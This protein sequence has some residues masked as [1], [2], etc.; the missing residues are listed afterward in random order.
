[1]MCYL[2]YYRVAVF[3]VF[4]SSPPTKRPAAMRR[5]AGCV[6]GLFRHRMDSQIVIPRFT[7]QL[8]MPER[9]G[10]PLSSG[11]VEFSGC[12]AQYIHFQIAFPLNGSKIIGTP[13][14]VTAWNPSEHRSIHTWHQEWTYIVVDK[15]VAVYLLF[16]LYFRVD[17][18]SRTSHVSCRTNNNGTLICISSYIEN[19]CRI[20][21]GGMC[22][23]RLPFNAN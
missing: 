17:M 2:E 8:S 20:I 4:V 13:F 7:M 15:S 1:M 14:Y 3:S 6:F 12:D 5:G 23:D 11:V 19:E 16:A 22:R 18:P 9:K 10:L 21:V